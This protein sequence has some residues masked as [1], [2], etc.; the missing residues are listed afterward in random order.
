M[1][2]TQLGISIA[3]E[4]EFLTSGPPHWCNQRRNIN[5]FFSSVLDALWIQTPRTEYGEEEIQN[6]G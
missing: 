1:S 4:L 6:F 2:K 3:A 5:L